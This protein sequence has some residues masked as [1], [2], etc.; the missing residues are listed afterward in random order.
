MNKQS[1]PPKDL[2]H[3]TAQSAFCPP[4]FPSSTGFPVNHGQEVTRISACS[5]SRKDKDV[6]S[7]SKLVKMLNE[8]SSIPAKQ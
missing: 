7:E 6:G 3:S 5:L 8:E 1:G 4:W 2:R